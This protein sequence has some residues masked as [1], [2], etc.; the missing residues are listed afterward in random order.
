MQAG[1]V[2]RDHAR[3]LIDRRDMAVRETRRN[4]LFAGS[5][6]GG[7][8]LARAMT[9]SETAKMSGLGPQVRRTDVL[10]RI[11][12]R[13]INWRDALLPWN[14]KPEVTLTARSPDGCNN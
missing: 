2:F 12:D 13:K 8:T 10:D 6:S 3:Q 14:C 4:R 5:D 11:Q 9:L 1:C 7:K